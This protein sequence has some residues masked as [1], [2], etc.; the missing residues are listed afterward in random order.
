MSDKKTEALKSLYEAS[1]DLYGYLATNEGVTPVEAH[2]W[3]RMRAALAMA[4][5]LGVHLACGYP[6]TFTNTAA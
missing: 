3:A 1:A 4:E 2:L 6:E 5:K